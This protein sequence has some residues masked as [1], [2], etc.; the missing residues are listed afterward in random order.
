MCLNNTEGSPD[1][2]AKLQ[3]S[4][5]QVVEKSFGPV[6][7]PTSWLLFHLVLLSE[8]GANPGYCTLEKCIKLAESHGIPSNTVE[9]LLKSIHKKF[10]TILYNNEVESLVK[11]VVCDPNIIFKLA[12]QLI[13]LSFGA[14]LD[15]PETS[16]KMRE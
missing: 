5:T 14:N 12:T 6:E 3:A 2:V 8:Y 7:L 11:L 9:D 15:R 4:I 13:V 1:E 16:K 10:G